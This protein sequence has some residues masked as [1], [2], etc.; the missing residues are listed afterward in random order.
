[1]YFW[2]KLFAV[3]LG[4][5]ALVVAGFLVSL[6][7]NILSLLTVQMWLV[8]FTST[9]T[10]HWF[11][12]F[13]G[14]LL[15]AFFVFLALLLFRFLLYRADRTVL[16]HTSEG[17]IKISYNSIRSLAKEALKDT[18]D[19][20]SMEAEVEKAGN[21]ARLLLH[22]GVRSHISV[23]E[24][25]PMVQQKVREKIKHHTGITLK[26]VKL[27]IDLQSEEYPAESPESTEITQE[28]ESH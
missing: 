11:F 8:G 19:L 7:L 15:A 10:Q 18:S 27:V 25:S 28:K 5:I 17:D 21:S 3:I 16:Y 24:F 13:L 9:F 2:G 4:L 1:M 23:S 12:Q 14:V 22:L 26:D 6:F 20:L